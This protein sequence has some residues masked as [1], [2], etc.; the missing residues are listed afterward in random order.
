M[1]GKLSL[2]SRETSLDKPS[3]LIK[4]CIKNYEKNF[5]KYQEKKCGLYNFLEL[6]GE[7]IT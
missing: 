4:P 6:L 3:K 2:Y 7:S 5:T 1:F